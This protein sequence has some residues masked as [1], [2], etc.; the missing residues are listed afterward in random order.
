[1]SQTTV[2]SVCGS[3]RATSVHRALL[4]IAQD[5]APGLRFV[6]TDL[7]AELPLFNADTEED[8]RAHPAAVREFRLLARASRGVVIA[9]PEYVHGPS[10]VTKNALDWLVGCGALYGKPTLLMSASPGATGGIRGLVGLIPTLQLLG[11]ELVDPVSFS[12]AGTRICEDGTVLDPSVTRRIRLALD[13]LDTALR[14]AAPAA[15]P[16]AASAPAGR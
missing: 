11:A 3:L 12:R 2:L 4:T 9:S 16:P 1:M 14:Y 8:E 10:G 5:L 15:A 7:V 6:G 13:E